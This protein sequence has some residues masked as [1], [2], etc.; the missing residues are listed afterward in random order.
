MTNAACLPPACWLA[1]CL[2]GSLRLIHPVGSLATDQLEALQKDG[3][4]EVTSIRKR[5]RP[6]KKIKYV[7]KK[8]RDD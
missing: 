2:A 4:Y 6:Q 7:E 1:G 8:T 5:Q 3:R